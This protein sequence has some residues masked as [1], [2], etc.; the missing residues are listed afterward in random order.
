MIRYCSGNGAILGR[1]REDLVGNGSMLRYSISGPAACLDTGATHILFREFD[2]SMLP[3]D[4]S[5]LPIDVYLPNGSA[6]ESQR[7]FSPLRKPSLVHI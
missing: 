2:A 3:S 4:L 7:T 1:E 5:A 6:I